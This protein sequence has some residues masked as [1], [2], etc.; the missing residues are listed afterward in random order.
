MFSLISSK[1]LTETA[2][3]ES[4]FAFIYAVWAGLSRSFAQ[5]IFP[6]LCLM[7]FTFA[8]PFLISRLLTLLEKPDDEATRREGYFL[9]AATGIMYIGSAV[10]GL[11]STH[12]LNR[13]M[14][15]FRGGAVSLIYDQTLLLK[16]GAFDE[17]SAVT[18]MGSDIDRISNCLEHLN[19]CWSRSL[20]IMI[21]VPLLTLQ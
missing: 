2:K 15:M 12:N 9:I 4:R 5:L 11:L 1:I 6:R 20:E 3:P 10:F 14:T 16:D 7:A 18:L 19:E 13:F 21:G 17:S 8:Q